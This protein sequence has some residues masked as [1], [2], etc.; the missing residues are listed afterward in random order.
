LI[1]TSTARNG[2]LG[3]G[4][5][6]GDGELV[7]VGVGVRVGM[8]VGVLVQVA[9]GMLVFVGITVG[10]LVAVGVAFGEAPHPT[11][12]TAIRVSRIYFMAFSSLWETYIRTGTVI[13]LLVRLAAPG[14]HDHRHHK[15]THHHKPFARR[16]AIRPDPRPNHAASHKQAQQDP[17]LFLDQGS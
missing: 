14:Q 10:V 7:S 15:Q 13:M 11:S 5:N 3:V 1:V 8:V 4:A 16:E 6:V 2:T 9:V 17:G 12:K